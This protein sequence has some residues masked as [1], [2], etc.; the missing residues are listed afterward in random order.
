MR[1]NLR[2]CK[3]LENELLDELKTQLNRFEL[4]LAM[5]EQISLQYIIFPKLVLTGL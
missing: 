2:I 1:G 5:P 4:T 3:I